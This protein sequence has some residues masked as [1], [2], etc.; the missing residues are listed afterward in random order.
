MTASRRS[1]P[2]LRPDPEYLKAFAE[3]MSRIERALGPKRP[4]KPVVVCVA[5]GA[6][7]HFYVGGRF[8]DDID[9]KILARVLLDP[10]DLQVAYRG[11]DG[12]ARLLYFDTQYNDSFALLHHNAYD[13]ARPI[14]VE[15]VDSRRLEVRL[16]TPLDL[17]VSKLSRYKT[18]DQ[19]DIRAL[20]GAGLIDAASL[21]R[22]AEEALPDYV[23]NLER[24]KTSIILACRL[25]SASDGKRNP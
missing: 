2:A 17:A 5:G 19:D 12:H 4:A 14:D 15:G 13:D 25:V 18:Q 10:Q 6:A 11:Q 23:G 20:A 1:V 8:T 16:L 22:R 7:M 24:I 21:R 3:I 9:A